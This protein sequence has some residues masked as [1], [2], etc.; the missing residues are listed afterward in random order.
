MPVSAGTVRFIRSGGVVFLVPMAA[1]LVSVIMPSFNA[2]RYVA[3]SIDSVIA[4]T[5]EDWELIVVD[6][7]STD[8]T[9]AIVAACQRRDSRIRLLPQR[10]NRGAAGARNLGLDQARGEWIGFIDSDDL[11]YPQKT[12]KQ[13]AAME[14][15]HADLSY[16]GY[17][18]RRDGRPA[19]VIVSVP[20]TVRYEKLLRRCLIACSTGMVRRATCGAVRMPPIRRRQDHGYWLELLRDGSRTAVGVDEPLVSYRV[21]RGS[22]SANKLIAAAYSWKLLRQVERIPFDKA[23]WHFAGYAAANVMFRLSMA[24]KRKT[25]S[26]R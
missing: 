22:L 10:T 20:D 14:A 21:H 26:G 19:G 7:A 13:I 25:A 16:T 9:T 11:W 12:A 18:R 15:S 24:M 17:E 8:A 2:E 4:Q 1:P 23:L 6:D 5:V 3:A